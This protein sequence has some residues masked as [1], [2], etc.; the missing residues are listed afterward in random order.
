MKIAIIG[1]GNMGGAIARGLALA[2]QFATSD[3]FV[4]NPSKGKLDAL[5][6]EFPEINVSTS[7]REVAARADMVMLVVKPWKVA[8]VIQELTDLL[9]PGKII[10]SVAGGVDTQSLREILLEQGV[11]V[12]A[13]PLYYIIP[14]TA[15]EVGESMTFLTSEHS[16]PELDAQITGIFNL[17]G[18]AIYVEPRMMAAGMA[19]ASCGIAYAMRYVRAMTTA[20]VELGLYPRDAEAAVAQTLKGAALLL[21]TN[22]SHPE[23]EID[24][25]TT[26]GGITIR[27]LNAMEEAG[28][29]GSIT[30]A[31][32]ATL[33]KI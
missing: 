6:C 17:V 20:G 14:N 3:I 12:D 27:G 26:A 23:A 31:L 25:V 16:T 4:S 33:P 29:T 7:N 13:R 18:K 24:R 30:R 11:S 8:G 19:V 9:V 5:K 10:A 28:F 2:P 21:E 15:M 22:G 1:A 32:R